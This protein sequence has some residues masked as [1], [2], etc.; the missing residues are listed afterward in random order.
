M[1]GFFLSPE[2]FLKKIR[3]ILML[4][5]DGLCLSDEPLERFLAA[6]FLQ[7]LPDYIPA[8]QMVVVEPVT[9][10]QRRKRKLQ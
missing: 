10:Q 8:G 2:R 9:L 5:G 7:F 6:L 1:P 3:E 4:F